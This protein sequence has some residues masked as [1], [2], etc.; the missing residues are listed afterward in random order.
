M[1]RAAAAL[2]LLGLV[3]G[4]RMPVAADGIMLVQAGSF[5]MGRDDGAAAEAPRHRLG[6]ADVW[7]ERNK[8]T[9]AEYAAFLNVRTPRDAEPHG[10]LVRIHVRGCVWAADIGFEQH[11]VAG[12]SWYGARDFCAWRGRRLPSEAE[13]E[14]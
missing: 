8:V 12:V 4:E 10:A 11:P 14:K 5:W 3:A 2:V 7:I 1:R 9:N 13:W 6:V